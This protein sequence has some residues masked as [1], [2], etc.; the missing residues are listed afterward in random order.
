MFLKVSEMKIASSFLMKKM[1]LRD[2]TCSVLSFSFFL[3]AGVQ[4]QTVEDFSAI[5]PTVVDSTT[6]LIMLVMSR[7]NQLW[8]KAYNDYSDLDGDGTLDTTYNDDFEYYGY[9]HSDLCYTYTGGVFYPEEEVAENSHKCDGDWSGN[10]MNWLTTTRIDVVRKVLYGGYRST[11]TTSSTILQRAFIPADNHA[12]VKVVDNSKI[13]GGIDDY[14][15]IDNLSVVSF[16][17]VTDYAEGA[18]DISGN[19]S[20]VTNPPLLKMAVGNERAWAGSERNQ[21]QYTEEG[22]SSGYSPSRPTESDITSI[23][24]NGELIV[25]ISTCSAALDSAYSDHCREYEDSLDNITKKPYGILQQHGED[26]DFRFGLMTGSYE[27]KAKGGVLRKNVTLMGGEDAADSDKEI[28]PETGIFLTK[29]AS[30]PGIINTINRL[31][32]QGWDYSATNYSDCSTY[33]ISISTF[34]TS[35]SSNRKCKDWGNPISELYTEA[36]RYFAAGAANTDYSASDS[37]LPSASWADPIPAEEPCS[38]CSIIVLSTGLNNFDGDDLNVSS[39]PALSGVADLKDITDAVGVAEGLNTGTYVVGEA[40]GGTDGECDAKSV[41]ALGDAEGPCPE[42]PRLEGTYNIAGAAYYGQGQDLR[43]TL[44]GEQYVKTYAVSLSETMPTFDIATTSGESVK[45]IPTCQANTTGSARVDWTSW[46]ACSLVDLTVVEEHDDG[47]TLLISWEDSMWGNDYD[48]D[49]YVIF[50]YCTATGT[51]SEVRSA[52]PKALNEGGASS[53]SLTLS[54]GDTNSHVSSTVPEWDEASTG[55]IQFRFA[56]VA[57]AAGNAL[58]FGYVLLG[59]SDDGAHVDELLRE[60]NDNFVSAGTFGGSA[61]QRTIWSRTAKKVTATVGTPSV[62]ENPLW[63]A[64]KY[65]NFTDINENGVP[66]LDSEWDAYRLDGSKG[67]D[68]VPDGYFPVSNPANLPAALGRIFDDL[69]ERV[70]AGSAAAV[71]AQ[72]GSGEGAVYQALYAPLVDQNDQKVSWVGSIHALFIDDQ[73]RIREDS[74]EPVLN[75]L[76]D[77][78][79]V[80]SFYFDETA[81]ETKIQ[82]YTTGGTAVGDPITFTSSEFSPIWSARDQLGAV[83]D[84]I[85][86]RVYSELATAGRYIFTSFDRDGDGNVISPTYSDTNTGPGVDDAAHAFTA[87]NFGFSGATATD[88]GYLGLANGTPE[89][90]V[91]NLVNFIRGEEGL[92]NSRSRT[93]SFADGSSNKYLLGDIVHSTPAI[94]AKPNAGYHLRYRDSTYSNFVES[95]RN[96]R[97]VIYVGA[98]DGMLHAFNAGFFDTTN[99][100]FNLSPASGTPVT[101]HPLGSELWGYVPFNLLPHLQWL[102]SELYP[103][104]YYMDG[105]VKAF[106]V[107][108]FESDGDH[109]DGWGTILVAGMRFGGGEFEVDHDVDY[110]EPSP[111]PKIPLRSGYV[112][113]DIT[114]PENP[115][116]LIAEITHPDLGYALSEP[117][118]VKYRVPKSDTGSYVN[119]TKNSWYLV[120]GSGPAGSTDAEKKAALDD[121]VSAKSAKLFTFDLINRSLAVQELTDNS[122][123][124]EAAS[125][126]GGVESVDWTSDFIDDAIYL[127]LVSGDAATPGGK[128]KRGKL[129][130]TE[131]GV[132]SISFAYDLFNDESLAFS[133]TPLAFKDVNNDYWVF[134]GTGRYYV[135]DDNMSTQ[136][137]SYFGIKEPKTSGVAAMD[138]TVSNSSLVDTTTVDVY[139]DGRVYD[140]KSAITLTGGGSSL[141]PETFEDIQE[142]VGTNGGWRFDL[143]YS[144]ED[145]DFAPRMRNTTKASMA[146]NSVIF[147]AYDATG[148]YCNSEG[149]G[150]IFAPYSNA[151]VPGPFAPL[152]TDSSDVLT[153]LVSGDPVPERVLWGSTL[154]V[155]VPS[156][157]IVTR[158]SGDSGSSSSGC[159]EYMALVQK[160]TGE[161]VNEMLGCESYTSGRQSWREIPVTWEM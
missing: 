16:C 142:F 140:E 42:V 135:A 60:G 36:L 155:G 2:I 154:G 27:N 126:V 136:Q 75:Q 57:A 151:G 119:T 21:C 48:M 47:G 52:C 41:T 69:S 143:H 117:A 156:S 87:A 104:V 160:S 100:Q 141:T 70:S 29:T 159:D 24:S 12:F 58:K 153:P 138:S 131:A 1:F 111:T 13:D 83:T 51:A 115:P 20:D 61:S 152:K 74:H 6:P 81:S 78:D 130:F 147:T 17:N 118:I 66:D 30:T 80:L 149:N 150:Y 10:F 96:R 34:L 98:N 112:I 102:Q 103:H 121:A 92:E 145:V 144:E 110:S 123:T 101:E 37:F 23:A 97:N 127:G 59:S 125:F 38:K 67:S 4:A 31:R 77:D 50:E 53:S 72:T 90:L 107:N 157:P 22:G 99:T 8:H 76:T 146:G 11:D 49:A 113:L 86:Q 129:S 84:Y 124:A 40:S 134:A 108:I 106:D 132:L 88:H 62:L 15:P 7:D 14:T 91:E 56:V 5:P 105:S 45:F 116:E 73:G 35:T 26:G 28:D 161:I 114:N 55:D 85:N 63:Y 9:F 3:S 139:T 68:G 43:G 54:G 65:G 122:G 137:Q 89:P 109:P 19:M 133:A 94:V 32:I 128:L 148:E 120:F 158:P 64:A 95:N 71:N 93:I 39:L 82:R 79:Y 18:S 44:I 25:R 46:T 33:G